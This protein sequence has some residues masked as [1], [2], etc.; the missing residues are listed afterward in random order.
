MSNPVLTLHVTTVLLSISGFIFRGILHLRDSDLL[1]RK[2]L[3]ISPHVNDTLLIISAIILVQQAGL[4]VLTTPWLQA[5]IVGLILYIA[6]GMTA[7]RFAKT[8]K[9]RLLAWIG[10][11]IVFSYIV[12][13]AVSKNPLVWLN[14]L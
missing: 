12:A 2:W 14:I 4:N 10:A 1:N 6:L 5:K 11:I 3:K 13:V 9:V 7:F 8:K